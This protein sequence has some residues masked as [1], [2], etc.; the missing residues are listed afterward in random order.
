MYTQQIYI[1]TI[2]I[3]KCPFDTVFFHE[4]NTQV[5]VVPLIYRSTFRYAVNNACLSFHWISLFS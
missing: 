1:T 2:L 5:P 3:F 4:Q